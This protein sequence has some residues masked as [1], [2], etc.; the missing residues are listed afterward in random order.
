LGSDL[1]LVTVPNADHWVHHDAPDLVSKTMKFWLAR[2]AS[3]PK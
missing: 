1:T 3:I 2:D